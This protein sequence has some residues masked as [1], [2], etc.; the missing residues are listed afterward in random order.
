LT[1]AR[2]G[3]SHRG[4]LWYVLRRYRTDPIPTVVAKRLLN[5]EGDATELELA[6][7]IAV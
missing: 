2:E 7:V 3:V 4:D 6:K 5:D 1:S